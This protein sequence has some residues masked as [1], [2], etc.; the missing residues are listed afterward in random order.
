MALLGQI[1]LMVLFTASMIAV[2]WLAWRAVQNQDKVT[3]TGA[4]TETQT[5][6]DT[7]H[8]ARADEKLERRD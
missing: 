6:T 8:E 7:H 5:E 4:E 3:E 1:L 2:G